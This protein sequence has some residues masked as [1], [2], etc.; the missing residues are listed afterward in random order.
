MFSSVKQTVITEIMGVFFYE[1]MRL[2]KILKNIHQFAN[3]YDM[4]AF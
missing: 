3:I 1:L 4:K 2:Q